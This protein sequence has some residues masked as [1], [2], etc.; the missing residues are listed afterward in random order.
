MGR[1]PSLKNLWAT[2]S[3]SARGG[4]QIY[5]IT[6]STSSPINLLTFSRREGR[7]ARSPAAGAAP[8]AGSSSSSSFST[9]KSR[10]SSRRGRLSSS[11]LAPVALRAMNAWEG[12]GEGES[13]ARRA[14]AAATRARAAFWALDY[15]EMALAEDLQAQ[16]SL[17]WED[18]GIW[19]LTRAMVLMDTDQNRSSADNQF[20]RA[21]YRVNYLRRAPSNATELSVT[22]DLTVQPPQTLYKAQHHQY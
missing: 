19:V 11:L 8:K 6:S 2:P 12:E 15:V 21:R 22:P 3:S 4:S 20:Y 14:R 1:S 7:P 9:F 18:T 17:A 10:R 5:L 16:G 13:A